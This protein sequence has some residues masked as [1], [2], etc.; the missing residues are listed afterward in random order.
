LTKVII[1]NEEWCYFNSLAIPPIKARVDSGAKTSSLHAFNIQTVKKNGKWVAR[2]SVHPFQHDRHQIID[3]EAIVID[4]RWIKNSS[5]HSER[6]LV[7]EA[8]VRLGHLE[9]TI[10]LTLANRDSMGYRML[11]GRNAM[12]DVL[13]D[14]CASFCL[15]EPELHDL[16][17]P[18]LLAGE[19]K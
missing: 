10:E 5:G 4:R 18:S 7:I 3:C 6:R 11:L 16:E 1:G 9:K 15:G 12:H 8:D 17:I 14:P 19:E 13:I 2:F